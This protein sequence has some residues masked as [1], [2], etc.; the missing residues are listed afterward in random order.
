MRRRRTAASIPNLATRL[1]TVQVA[2]IAVG[3]LVLALSAALV[4]P[5][6]FHQHLSRAGV[7]DSTV[8]HHAEEAFTSSFEL[9]LTAA[10]LAALLTAGLMSFLLVRRVTKPVEQL[11][12]AADAVAAGKFDVVV[13]SASYSSELHRLSVA[14]GQMAARLADTDA[15][16]T[17]LLS[18]LS[19]E[20]R[21]PLATLSAFIDG[22]EDGVVP[23]DAASWETMRGQV[24]RLRRLATDVREAAAAEEAALK[25]SFAS[26]DIAAVVRGVVDATQPRY[27][28]AGV[29]L[30][31]T[32][33]AAVPNVLGD[34][35]RLAQVVA[36]LLDNALRHTSPVGHVRVTVASPA[37][38]LL[39]HVEDDGTGIP[40]GEL[41]KIFER[42][43]RGDPSRADAPGSGSGLGL[44][45]ARAIVRAHGGTLTAASAGRDQGATFTMSLPTADPSR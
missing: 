26:V 14:F 11:A 40:T 29:E 23:I 24:S 13:P 19:H 17:K 43:Y 36:N 39:L 34:P 41:E 27:A 6:L 7:T 10:A 44:T 20:L 30:T 5:A 42:F 32:V 25:M 38:Q 15:A 37:G 45:I 9:S 1:M 28:A 21:T 2:V 16:R 12:V 33:Q 4:A 8:R 22:M 31:F 18:D 35:G 3:S